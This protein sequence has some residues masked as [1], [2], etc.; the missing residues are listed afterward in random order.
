MPR[1]TSITSQRLL[2]IGL[3]TKFY[4]PLRN[5]STDPTS[6]TW[7]IQHA[8]N[9]YEFI[10][11]D[12]IYADGP[13]R[14]LTEM[15][16]GASS[17][18]DSDITLWDT[19]YV[20]N[21]N[22]AFLN[23]SSFNRDIS[24]WDT[25]SV[26]DMSNMFNGCT[27]FNQSINSWDTGLVT[28]FSYM[29]ANAVVFDSQIGNWDTSSATNLSYMFNNASSFNQNI[30]SWYVNNV[31]TLRRMFAGCGAYNQPLNLWFTGNVTNFE[32]LFADCI[33]FNQNIGNWAT[34]NVTNMSNTFFN[35]FVFDQDLTQWCVSNILEEPSGFATGSLLNPGN[36]PF[37]GSCPTPLVDQTEFIRYSFDPT[38]EIAE[39]TDESGNQWTTGIYNTTAANANFTL[40][41][42]GPYGNGNH[43]EPIRDEQS[44]IGSLY[45]N[46]TRLT[47]GVQ[48]S[49][50]DTTNE[51]SWEMWAQLPATGIGEGNVQ[52]SFGRIGGSFGF[53]FLRSDT[54][55]QITFSM[56]IRSTSTPS[57]FSTYQTNIGN[58]FPV[59]QWFHLVV[60]W[61]ASSSTSGTLSIWVNGTR[62][63]INTIDKTESIGDG[64]FVANN[65]DGVFFVFGGDTTT[66]YPWFGIDDLRILRNNNWPASFTPPTSKYSY[67]PT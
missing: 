52:Q 9:G 53:T 50:F 54:T 25:S 22:S 43:V 57:T 26:T 7:R 24:S 45:I 48:N 3:V 56:D 63:V 40:D 2:G 4:Y 32:G 67:T 58:I 61:T 65:S 5:T 34:G 66:N 14:N 1:L 29:F 44:N 27:Q 41:F 12:G 51:W 55:G 35:T 13:L 15:F 47:T 62:Q 49:I 60:G 38:A 20:T 17:F 30:N 23:A 33:S 28:N 8:P 16:S 64:D 59:N 46:D 18:N 19:R 10:A 36:F 42:G 37:W 39:L 6:A 31:T 11:N 21:M